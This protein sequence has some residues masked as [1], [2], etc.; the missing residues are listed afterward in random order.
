MS[1]NFTNL[2]KPNKNFHYSLERNNYGFFETKGEREE[3]NGT[4]TRQDM[5]KFN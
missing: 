2:S 3:G 5:L 1:A 4:L